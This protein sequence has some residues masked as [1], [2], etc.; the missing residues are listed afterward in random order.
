VKGKKSGEFRI[1]KRKG[2]QGLCLQKRMGQGK[3]R[4]LHVVAAKTQKKETEGAE[5]ALQCAIST[6]TTVWLS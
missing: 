6:D 1:A 3:V 4:C 2:D 5:K